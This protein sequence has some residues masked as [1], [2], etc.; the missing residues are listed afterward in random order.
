M[1]MCDMDMRG[2]LS[3]MMLWLL[4]RQSM[5]GSALAEELAKRRGVRPNPG[6][7]YPALKV[8]RV[9]RA[10]T[11]RVEGRQ[12]IYTL[13]PYGKKE[14]DRNVQQFCKMFYDVFN[15]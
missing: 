5:S 13:T 8:L 15:E 9:R 12:K 14:L 4:S 1:E 2:Y 6:T 3:F 7:I 10:V 11:I